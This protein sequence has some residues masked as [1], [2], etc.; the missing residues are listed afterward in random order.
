MNN[1]NKDEIIAGSL[2]ELENEEYAF[3][4]DF[5]RN[6]S[7]LGMID[8]SDFHFD[9]SNYAFKVESIDVLI[10]QEVLNI[11]KIITKENY[12]FSYDIDKN[13]PVNLQN[14]F[15]YKKGNMIITEIDNSINRLIIITASD[16]DDYAEVMYGL[17]NIDKDQLEYDLFFE[18]IEELMDTLKNDKELEIINII[19][20]YELSF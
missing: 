5:R 8:F 20:D 16:D 19:E 12:K 15:Y 9:L 17:I 2:L 14:I 7:F 10:E 3:I 4:F 13:P 6:Y 18:T 11:N 1:F